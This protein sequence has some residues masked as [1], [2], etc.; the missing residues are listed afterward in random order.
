MTKEEKLKILEEAEAKVFT[1]LAE[2]DWTGLTDGEALGLFHA[3][4]WLQWQIQDLQE[5]CSPDECRCEAKTDNPRPIAPHP[6]V[7]VAVA[8]DPVPEE[9]NVPQPDAAKGEAAPT[10]T[11]SQMV[12][13]LTAFRSNGVAIDAVM[14]SMGYA[15]LSQ[16]PA[17]RYW[18][19]LENCQKIAD[20]EG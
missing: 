12:T 2:L 8:K 20:G 16:V 14:Q 18:E 15:K 17:G 1:R 7:V 4:D 9:A 6:G 5:P 11:K 19:L 13:K 3:I 10:L